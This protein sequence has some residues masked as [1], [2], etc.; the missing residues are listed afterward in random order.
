MSSRKSC[1]G[2][3]FVTRQRLQLWADTNLL[4]GAPLPGGLGKQVAATPCTLR[5][6]PNA[7]ILCVLASAGSGAWEFDARTGARVRAHAC[8][9]YTYAYVLAC[10]IPYLFTGLC[11]VLPEPSRYA[12]IL[13][14]Q[15]GSCGCILSALLQALFS[16]TVFGICEFPF[17]VLADTQQEPVREVFSR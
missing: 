11:A 10:S 16:Q 6:V 13:P 1:A 3:P 4:S 14:D 8:Y 9:L 15:V 12:Q 5:I 17:R 7:C 2:L